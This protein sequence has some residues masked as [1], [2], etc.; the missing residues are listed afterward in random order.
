MVG[1]GFLL[2]LSGLF[3]LIAPTAAYF[4]DWMGWLDPPG[5]RRPNR[6]VMRLIGLALTIVGAALM[7]VA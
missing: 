5:T 4:F 3:A 6:L 7:A 1:F 2:L